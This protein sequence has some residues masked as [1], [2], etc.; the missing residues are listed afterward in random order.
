MKRGMIIVLLT[1]ILV[2]FTN[3]A[4]LHVGSSQTYSTIQSA[5]NAANSGDV[6]KVHPGTYHETVTITKSDLT[7]EAYNPANPPELDG[8]DQVFANSAHSWTN[9]QGKIYSTT[10]DLPFPHLTPVTFT[11]PKDPYREGT[12]HPGDPIMTLYED[13]VWLRGYEGMNWNELSYPY[14]TLED[15]DYLLDEK[16]PSAEHDI[17][18]PGR[19]MYNDSTNKLYVW[20]ADE[21]HPSNHKYHIPVLK[22]LIIIDAPDVTIRNLVLKHTYYYAI[23]IGPSGDRATIENNYVVNTGPWAVYSYNAEDVELKNNFIQLNGFYERQ[24]YTSA[25]FNLLKGMLVSINGLSSAKNCDISENVVT[26]TYGISVH[27]QNCRVHGNIVS[28]SQSILIIPHIESTGA[29]LGYIQNVSVYNNILHHSGFSAFTSYNTLS[30]DKNKYYGPVYFYRNLIYAVENINKDGCQES[31]CDPTP[32][33]FIYQNTFLGGSII[34]HPYA[35]PVMKSTIYRNNIFYIRYQYMDMYWIYSDKDPNK[36]WSYFPFTNGPD[37]DYNLYWRNPAYSWSQIARFRLTTDTDLQSY[38]EGEFSLM[39][40]QTGLD[41]HGF[42][43]DPLFANKDTL[44]N[45]NILN[46]DYDEISGMNYK[47]VIANGYN[48]IYSQKFNDLYNFFVVASDSPAIDTGEVLPSSWPDTVTITDGKPDIGAIEYGISIPTCSE[49]QITS[50]CLCGGVEYSS[51][52]CCSNVWQD[53]PCLTSQELIAH[54]KFDEGTGITA[55]DSSGN[56]NSGNINGATWTTGK[57]G[58]ALNF[59]GVDDYVLA[60]NDISLNPNYLTTSLWFKIDNFVDNTGLIAKGD[61]SNRQ[62]WEWI[63][64]GNIS[65]EIDE[66]GHHNYLYPLQ[67]DVWYYLTITYDGSNV[68]TFIN[69]DE[70]SSILQSTGTILA[71]DDSLYIGKLLGYVSFDGTIDDVRIYNYAL[72]ATE[73]SDLYNL[74]AGSICGPSDSDSDGIVTISELIDYIGEWKIGNVSIEDLIDAIG[75]WKSGC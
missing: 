6:V 9:V 12:G 61:N 25:R 17:R 48:N 1:L 58:S 47:D 13:E 29:P 39:Q 68:K 43:V 2:S 54:Y 65:L 32:D 59:D 41:S 72:S 30:E 63:Y 5:V 67:S 10:Y 34:N 36:D 66:G 27:G 40:Q 64:Q 42:K 53:T 74:G 46:M 15:L 70:V 38:K 4:T 28:K 26:G 56:S 62:Y 71:D 14:Y 55:Y 37:S 60:N 21:D 69:G 44:D 35:Y 7:I 45:Y 18:I 73:I 33:T 24:D 3:A 57:I 11:T 31:L 49:G 51:G 8:A 16:S 23:S 75:K 22:N 50:T 52:Y 19:F 20:S